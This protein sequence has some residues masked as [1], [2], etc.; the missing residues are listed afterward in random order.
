MTSNLIGSTCLATILAI[1]TYGCMTAADSPF[2][3]SGSL[4]H[5]PRV[6]KS[7]SSVAVN[8]PACNYSYDEDPS[9]YVKK[10]TIKVDPGF[11]QCKPFDSEDEIYVSDK[12]AGRNHKVKYLRPTEIITEGSCRYC[13]VNS[14]GG[15][16]C[17]TY[18][19]PFCP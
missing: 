12:Q 4:P 11:P 18:S 17:V 13:Y 8:R 6:E 16:S 7:G 5:G 14:S 9:G 15:M 2:G 1:I 19:G 10:G 3:L